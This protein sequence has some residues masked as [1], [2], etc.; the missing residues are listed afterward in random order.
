M[1]DTYPSKEDY[2][3]ETLRNDGGNA[4]RGLGAAIGASVG[5]PGN[6]IAQGIK[7]MGAK[8]LSKS[9]R[10]STKDM[11]RASKSLPDSPKKT[12]SKRKGPR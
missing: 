11:E 4:G 1:A 10:V 2:T 6:L 9:A 7:N 12:K 3:K 5:G 8:A